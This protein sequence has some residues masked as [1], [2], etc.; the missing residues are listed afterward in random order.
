MLS[1][2]AHIGFEVTDNMTMFELDSVTMILNEHFEEMKKSMDQA[3]D[4][5]ERERDVRKDGRDRLRQLVKQLLPEQPVE[6]EQHEI[7][8]APEHKV[9]ARP[10]PEPGQRPD[11][12]EIQKC[13]RSSLPWLPGS[14]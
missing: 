13:A 7:I 9:P 14:K 5:R 2:Y 10:M 6:H 8:E 12:E 11:D 1:K 3:K 4:N